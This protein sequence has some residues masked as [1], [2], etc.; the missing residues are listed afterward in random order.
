MSKKE[1]YSLPISTYEYIT[2]VD[3]RTGNELAKRYCYYTL[4]DDEEVIKN[5]KENRK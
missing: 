5:I 3:E 1:D 2:E 4:I